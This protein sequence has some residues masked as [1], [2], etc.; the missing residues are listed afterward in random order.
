MG[1]IQKSLRIG[2][3]SCVHCQNEMERNLKNTP[4]VQDVSVS[5]ST[6][7]ADIVYDSEIITPKDI[8]SIVEA[9]GYEVLPETQTSKPDIIRTVS[10]LVIIVLLCAV[11]SIFPSVSTELNGSA[12]WLTFVQLFCIISAV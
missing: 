12:D 6:G 4:G 5:Y 3:M 9:L 11:A 2:R 8:Q 1:V 7:I 10:L